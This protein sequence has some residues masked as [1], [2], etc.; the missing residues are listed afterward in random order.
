M[1]EA[2]LEE[3]ADRGLLLVATSPRQ[4]VGF[5]MAVEQEGDLHLA[6]MAVHPDHGGRGWGRAL[7]LAV[8]E[9]ASRRGTAGVTLTT[10][11]DLPWNGPFYRK[12]GFRTL[13]DCELSPALRR[14]LAHE[15]SLGMVNRVAMRYT[16]A[17]P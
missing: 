11:D 8:M 7:L 9:E 14:I 17:S 4:I 10:F 13:E 6:V 1:P 12:S 16:I 15:T 2:D 3:A 5:A